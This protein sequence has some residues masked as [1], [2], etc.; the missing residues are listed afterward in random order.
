MKQ[1]QIDRIKD[2]MAA[3]CI[4]NQELAAMCNISS[5][6]IGRLLT[7]TDYNPTT[8]TIETIANALGVHEQY[9]YEAEADTKSKIPLNGY[10]EFNNKVSRIKTFEELENVFNGIK[11]ILNTPELAKSLL[12]QDEA[13]RQTQSQQPIDITTI[14]LSKQEQYDTSK[15]YTWSFRKSDD[16]KEEMMN[17]LGNMCQ[18]YPFKVAGEQFLN[19]ECAYISGMFSQNTPKAIEIQKEL[20]ASD[21]GYQAKK[22]IR[23][24]Y[25]QVGF[26]REDWNTFNVQW[27]LYVVWQKVSQN[28]AFAKKLRKIPS[29]AMIVENSTFQKGETSDFWGMKNQ[30]IKDAVP[31]LETA[32]EVECFTSKKKDKNNAKMKA[33]NSVNHIGTWEGVN[34]MGKILTI[35][36]HC[37]ENGTEPPIDYDLLRSKQ[38]HLFGNLLTFDDEAMMHLPKK[39]NKSKVVISNETKTP[40]KSTDGKVRGIIG[41]VIGEVVGSRFEFAKSLPKKR[42]ELFANQCSF[43]DDTVL[44]IAIADSLLHNK[45]FQDTLWMWGKKY[46]HAGFGRSFKEWLK[47]KKKDGNATND[48]KGNGC[49][50][51][52]SPIGFYAKTLDEALELAKQSAIITHNSKEGI[53]GAQSI[54]AAT[55]LAKEQRP[56]H[57]IRAYLEE[58]FGYN[59]HITDEDIFDNKRKLDGNEKALAETTCPLA[60]IAFLVTEDYESAIR[61]AIS[62]HADTDTV[63]CMTGG[64]AAAYYGVPQAIINEVAD[65]LPQEII[66]I[67]NEFD[68]IHIENTRTTPK[69]SHRWGDIYVYG[70]GDNKNGE[71]EAFIASKYFGA[72]KVIE[73]IDKRAY[74]IPVVGRSLDDIK[75]AVERFIEYAETH[76]DKTF[77]VTE[78]GCSKA[79]YTPKDIAPMFE[80]AKAMSNVYLPMVFKNV[81]TIWEKRKKKQ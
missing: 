74:A 12:D 52:V 39:Q 7:K 20:Q 30:A 58:T 75:L 40:L 19:S 77:L 32:A 61:K 76:Q 55:Y 72:G 50:M 78:I 23:R 44:T 21:N 5:M 66:D 81:P 51:R 31:I 38:I 42:Y 49:G 10:I 69:D 29:Y 79:G 15:L 70:S 48:S 34:C 45:E 24:K 17:D 71:T 63:A 57:E 35:C 33:R 25:E 14:D 65:Y 67:I 8:D 16:E 6:T 18:G 73:G 2:L 28:K 60:I 54:A 9:I 46:P 4:T 13:N 3:K 27:M 80:K 59:L 56:K 36:K 53:R 1:Y 37:L 22:S 47:R 26:S 62:Y 43:T 11:Q 41:A 68:G 64:I